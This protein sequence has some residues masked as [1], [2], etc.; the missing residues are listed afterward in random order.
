M[1]VTINTDASFHPKYK[2]GAFAFWVVSNEFKIQKAGFFKKNCKS[3]HGAEM[4][5]II[6]A[7]TL[8]LRT[9]TKI[10]KIIIN[11][12]SMNSISIFE[13]DRNKINRYGLHYGAKYRRMFRNKLK[14][15]VKKNQCDVTV[16]FRHV[17][18]HSG[19]NDKRSY[20]NDWCDK[21]AKAFL[22]RRINELKTK[23]DGK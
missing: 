8:T 1:L 5:C 10:K 3:S 7:L 14:M 4:K 21:H 16:E 22:W 12:D 23:K 2:I 13:N 6:N 18:A 11:T 20:V 17:K 15:Y 9:N 19:V